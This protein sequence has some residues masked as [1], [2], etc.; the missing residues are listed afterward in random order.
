MA[1]IT[2]RVKETI[3]Q[4]I[5]LQYKFSDVE[6]LDV[7]VCVRKWTLPNYTENGVQDVM[8]NFSTLGE[9]FSLICTR[10]WDLR[11]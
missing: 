7:K 6:L 8:S 10:P 2:S 9:Q 1:L 4:D 3:P 11:E 5:S